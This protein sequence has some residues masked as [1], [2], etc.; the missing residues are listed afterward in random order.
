MKIYRFILA[1]AAALA[2]SSC[3]GDLNV[4]PIDPSVGTPEKMLTSENDYAALLA[5]CYQGL[6]VSGSD[7]ANGSPDIDGIDGGFGQYMRALF[8][9]NEYTTD[10]ATCPWNDATVRS[11]HGLSFTASDVFVTAMFSRVFYQIEICNEFIRKAKVSEYAESS[12]MKTYIDEARALRAL[13]YYHA[14]DMFGN[15]PFSTEEDPI[16]VA[17]GPDQLSRADL[18]AWLDQECQD[19]ISGG[20]LMSRSN[21]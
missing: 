16:S 18:F 7:G 15:V 5:K 12:N 6:C 3:V 8:Y 13:S 2:L 11:L 17:E 21:V 14:M 4:T 9:M 20:N 1:A 19:L 10:E